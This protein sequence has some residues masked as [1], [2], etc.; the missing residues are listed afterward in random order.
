[1]KLMQAVQADARNYSGNVISRAMRFLASAR[2]WIVLAGLL[3]VASA[4]S[5]TV[6]ADFESCSAPGWTV[7]GNAWTVGGEAAYI[8]PFGNCFARSGAPNIQS[9]DLAESNSGSILS[10]AFTVDHDT[11]TW[12]AVGWSGSQYNSLNYYQV[13]ASDMTVKAVVQTP[14]SDSWTTASVN[15]LSA[16]F[17]AGDVFYFK[18]VDGNTDP[19]YSWLAFDNLAL[20]GQLQAG[21]ANLG[22]EVINPEPSGA[23]LLLSGMGA[24]AYA[25]RRRQT[26]RS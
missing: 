26:R 17:A 18:A 23:I 24:L 11:L 15:L 3:A 20:T 13:L 5:A 22:N 19:W 1:M 21:G 6:I 4:G 25:L 7:T 9:G 10:P 8:Y 2:S 16:G 12:E 14:Q